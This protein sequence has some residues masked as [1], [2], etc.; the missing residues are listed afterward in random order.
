MNQAQAD[1]LEAGLLDHLDDA[2]DGV[3]GDG[4]WLHDSEGTFDG[5]GSFSIGL[6]A[7]ERTSFARPLPSRE[8]LGTL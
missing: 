7:R 2:P 4:V 8:G 3:L 1:D 5:H 6:F